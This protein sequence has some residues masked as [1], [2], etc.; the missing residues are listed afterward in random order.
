MGFFAQIAVFFLQAAEVECVV[1]GNDDLVDIQGFFDEIEGAQFGRFDGGFHVAMA[2]DDDHRQGG[3]VFFDF[4]QCFDAVDSGHPD[5]QQHQVRCFGID[6]FQ[7]FVAIVGGDDLEP[8]VGEP[9]R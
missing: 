7:G 3:A 4:F 5:V 6:N 1:D 2:G 9:N 8:F